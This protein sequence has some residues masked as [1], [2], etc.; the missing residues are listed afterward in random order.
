MARTAKQSWLTL[1]PAGK[2][3]FHKGG[4]VVPQVDPPPSPPYV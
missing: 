1:H 2:A 4:G 3:S